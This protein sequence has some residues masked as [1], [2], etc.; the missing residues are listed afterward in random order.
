MI[1]D[2]MLGYAF[3]KRQMS[4]GGVLSEIDVATIFKVCPTVV[5]RS[6]R[7]YEKEHATMVPRRGTIHDL[8]RSVSHKA[9]ICRKKLTENKSTS[10]IVQQTHHTAEAVDRYLKGLSEAL[11]CTGRG[12]SIKDISFITSMSNGLVNQ[13]V[14]LAKSL[15]PEDGDSLKHAPHEE[16]T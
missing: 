13:Y 7:A 6:I 16:E 2:R 12:M 9:T 3:S 1:L 11:F 15:T 8:G 14:K 4:K 5:S 10:Q